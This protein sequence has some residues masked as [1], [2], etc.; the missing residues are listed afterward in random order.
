MSFPASSMAKRS[1]CASPKSPWRT[2]INQ[3][4]VKPSASS[5]SAEKEKER[6]GL[7]GPRESRETVNRWKCS[8]ARACARTKASLFK[9]TQHLSG[10][11]WRDLLRKPR[12]CVHCRRKAVIT[13]LNERFVAL[14]SDDTSPVTG[15]DGLASIFR[16]RPRLGSGETR[17]PRF[18]TVSHL[19]HSRSPRIFYRIVW[20]RQRANCLQLRRWIIERVYISHFGWERFVPRRILGKRNSLRG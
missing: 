20:L 6:N 12:W 18:R 2:Q 5:A 17:R 19:V 16:S 10:V 14:Y 7:T 4:P 9:V 13:M 15:C 11:R 8:Y 3:R 1:M